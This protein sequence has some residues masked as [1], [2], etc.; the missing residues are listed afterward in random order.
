MGQF[1]TSSRCQHGKES[2]A[3]QNQNSILLLHTY[4]EI[5]FRIFVDGGLSPIGQHC[6]RAGYSLLW[7]DISLLFAPGILRKSASFAVVG[8]GLWCNKFFFAFKG[9]SRGRMQGVPTPPWDE[10][11]FFVWLLKFV[12]LT[13]Q[14][15]HFLEVHPLLRKVF[16]VILKWREIVVTEARRI[17][18]ANGNRRTR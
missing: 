3:M 13:G 4:L 11:F 14:W 12:Y 9:V 10:A 18:W 16:G 2:H 6:S 17:I 7:T 1:L 5:I 15:R 8:A